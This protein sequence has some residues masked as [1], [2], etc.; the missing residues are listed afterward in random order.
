MAIVSTPV[1]LDVSIDGVLIGSITY[2]EVHQLAGAQRQ[3]LGGLRLQRRDLLRTG[4]LGKGSYTYAVHIFSV[5]PPAFAI[6][7][8]APGEAIPP[9]WWM[10]PPTN[11]TEGTP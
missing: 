8:A 7:K 11:P 1:Q 6:Y 9:E 3:A 2:D 4:E 10:D 5:S